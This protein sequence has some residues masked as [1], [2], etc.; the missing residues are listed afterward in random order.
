MGKVETGHPPNKQ[1]TIHTFQ[2][3]FPRVEKKSPRPRP[4]STEPKSK[5]RK[6]KEKVDE[7]DDPVKMTIQQIKQRLIDAHMDD[8][9]P[10]MKAP[11]QQYIEIYRKYISTKKL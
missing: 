6:V 8:K 2:S 1:Y 3:K 4:P 11:K 9:L 7:E 5:R 10:T